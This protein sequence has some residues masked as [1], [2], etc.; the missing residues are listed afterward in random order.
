MMFRGLLITGLPGVG[1]TTLARALAESLKGAGRAAVVIDGDDLR[2]AAHDQDFSLAGR[3]R[4]AARAMV[5]AQA[6]MADGVI[7]LVALVAPDAALRAH[8]RRELPGLGEVLVVHAN[9]AR[10]AWPGT[11]YEISQPDLALDGAAPAALATV[12]LR[13]SL[14]GE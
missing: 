5:A 9:A 14:I 3:Q 11:V 13:A 12:V 2:A 6:A 1:K 4:Q 10:P 8:L 7:P